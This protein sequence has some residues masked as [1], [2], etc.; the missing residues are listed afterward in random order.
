MIKMIC[1][2]CGN[3]CHLI[4]YDILIRV[5]H[6][7]EPV[8]MT[9]TGYPSITDDNT[10]IRMVLCQD[11]YKKLGLPNPYT[12]LRDKSLIFRD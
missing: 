4:G 7:P 8:S 12:A 9:D 11:C 2:K 3:D 10:S 5:L 6:N 1:D